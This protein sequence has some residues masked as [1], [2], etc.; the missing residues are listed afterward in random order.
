MQAQPERDTRIDVLR[1]LALLTIYIDHVPG[2]L[3]EHLTYKNFGFSDAAEAF[4]LISGISVALAYGMKFQPGSRLAHDAENVAARRR[5]LCAHIVTTDRGARHLL[6]RRGLCQAAR[7]CCSRS[8]SQPVIDK[9]PRRWSASSRSAIRSATTT[10][11]R[12]MRCCC[13]LAPAFLL[14]ASYQAV[15]GADCFPE[16]CGWRPAS[17]RSRRPT[18]PSRASGSSIRCPGNSCST[19]AWSSMMHVRRGGTHPGQS[20]AGRRRGAL[21]RGVA[22]LGAQPALGQGCRG[23]A[24]LPC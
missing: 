12:S 10:S 3:F 6:R 7:T 18:I 9:P 23:S 2:T 4:V 14:I 19:S 22:G 13:W 21:C 8:T 24:C 20:L 1:A 15:A 11:C 17:S 5:A 16:R